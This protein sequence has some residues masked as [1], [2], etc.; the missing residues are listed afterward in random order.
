[1][2]GSAADLNYSQVNI[3]K[4]GQSTSLRPIVLEEGGVVYAEINHHH[5]AVTANQDYEII[6][7]KYIQDVLSKVY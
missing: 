1:M 5:N 7:G 3:I 2:V 4:T 6:A